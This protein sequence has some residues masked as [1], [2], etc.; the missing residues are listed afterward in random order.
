MPIKNNQSESTAAATEVASKHDKP[1]TLFGYDNQ[2]TH[3]PLVP[4]NATGIPPLAT[5]N[6][7]NLPFVHGSENAA[8]FPPIRFYGFQSSEQHST[9][10]N[11]HISYEPVLN[12]ED[13]ILSATVQLQQQQQH[14]SRSQ[15]SSTAQHVH[16][17]GPH[18]HAATFRSSRQT[19]ATDLPVNT[20]QSST[21]LKQ[22]L[23][24]YPQS[25]N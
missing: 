7:C 20:F 6:D 16:R 24:F 8:F 3:I 1:H 18:A 19:A 10:N 23:A 17:T 13:S 14:S 22:H 15:P 11:F 21:D 2:G 25:S 9:E 5:T 12:I 4:W